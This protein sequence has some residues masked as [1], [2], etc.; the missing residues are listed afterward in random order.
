ML[1]SARAHVWVCTRVPARPEAEEQPEAAAEDKRQPQN[2]SS[3]SRVS[4]RSFSRSSPPIVLRSAGSAFRWRS[5]E[6][7]RAR[8]RQSIDWRALRNNHFRVCTNARWC[9]QAA[10][11]PGSSSLSARADLQ[12]TLARCHAGQSA[13]RPWTSGA[14]CNW[15]RGRARSLCGSS[16]QL[17]VLKWPR[18]VAS[19]SASSVCPASCMLSGE[20]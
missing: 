19:Q 14:H 17:I 2:R 20:A 11:P 5:G 7:V 1:I 8:R 4:A 3:T 12:Q 9:G 18:Q 16:R 15:G 10:V 6:H 13:R